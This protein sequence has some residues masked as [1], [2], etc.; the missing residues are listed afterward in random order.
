MGVRGLLPW[1]PLKKP[2]KHIVLQSRMKY[3]TKDYTV[4]VLDV[5]ALKES[6]ARNPILVGILIPNPM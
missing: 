4:N 1:T 6:S 3:I 2:E 5:N